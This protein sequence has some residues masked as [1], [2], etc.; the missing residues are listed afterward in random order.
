MRGL[1]C[2]GCD[3]GVAML[4]RTTR[5]GVSLM[6]HLRALGR[7]YPP[8][9]PPGVESLRPRRVGMS[10][11]R[12]WET[13]SQSPDDGSHHSRSWRCPRQQYPPRVPADHQTVQQSLPDGHDRYASSRR[14]RH[15]RSSSPPKPLRLAPPAECGRRLLMW[16]AATRRAPRRRRLPRH[17]CL[18]VLARPRQMRRLHAYRLEPLQACPLRPP[19]L[20]T[21][22]PHPH[23]QVRL[24]TPCGRPPCAY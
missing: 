19:P 11:A 20:R 10:I 22:S 18:R 23:P 21:C 5:C 14:S 13:A 1:R 8:G 6:I 24:A 4:A 12:S 3:A 7:T 9:L 2:G 17:L 16:A 15:R